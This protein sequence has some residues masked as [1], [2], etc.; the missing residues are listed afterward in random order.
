MI[1]SNAL[2][3]AI[4]FHPSLSFDER[5][6]PGM[7]ALLRDVRTNEPCGVHRTFLDTNGCKLTRRMLGRAQ[8]AAVKLDADE[9]V[10]TSLTIGEG[11]ETCLAARQLGF[12]PVWAL[13]SATAIERFPV[14]TGI[15]TLRILAE[16]DES[17]A[18]A[19]AID[20]CARRW[21]AASKEVLIVQ[22]AYGD[23]NDALGYMA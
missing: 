2:T 22:P 1:L 18:N 7:V 6:I 19:R 8:N 16:H 13:G 21:L 11:V 20:A 14:L 4:R 17:G 3:C 10:T 15:E 5:W 12:R 23:I 9:D